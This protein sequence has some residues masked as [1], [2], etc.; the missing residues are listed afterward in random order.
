[1]TCSKR[2]DSINVTLWF[3]Y[4]NE[5]NFFYKEPFVVDYRKRNAILKQ[6]KLIANAENKSDSIC[7]SY[8]AFETLSKEEA[9][10]SIT[11]L[12]ILELKEKLHCNDLWVISRCLANVVFS[13]MRIS[14]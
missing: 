8:Q 4:E 10:N 6:F 2:N 9:N 13:C 5:E 1:M 14:K 3:K 12:E 11:E 7:L